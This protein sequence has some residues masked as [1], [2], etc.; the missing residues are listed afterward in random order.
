MQKGLPL[1]TVLSAP[2]AHTC[3]LIREGRE[4]GTAR[5]PRVVAALLGE[6]PCVPSQGRMTRFKGLLCALSRAGPVE[7]RCPSKVPPPET[8]ML[9]AVSLCQGSA[10][11]SVKD[12]IV[13]I[14]SF[15]GHVVWVMA[16]QLCPDCRKTAVGNPRPEGCGWLPQ[17]WISKNGQRAGWVLGP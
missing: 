17:K 1:R 8:G 11:F 16:T 5:P 2:D 6:V 10:T 13:N 7:S 4:G 3:P 9:G 14:L 12:P 15:E